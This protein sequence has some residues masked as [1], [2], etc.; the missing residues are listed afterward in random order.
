M[1]KKQ[2]REYAKRKLKEFERWQRI[3]QDDS[4][5]YSDEYILQ[6]ERG[7]FQPVERL[8]INRETARQE[9]NAIKSA[10]NSISD[11]R[12]RQILISNY[13]ERKTVEQ[14]R[15]TIKSKYQPYEAIKKSQYNNL[16]NTALLAFAKQ[17]RNGILETL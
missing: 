13:L 14:V 6:A 16:K 3:A 4:I 1:N 7:E 10:I 5:R 9:L 15:Q 8:E 11:I 12:L 17:Y 2:V